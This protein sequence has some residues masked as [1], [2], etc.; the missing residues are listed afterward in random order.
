[1][2]AFAQGQGTIVI[3]VLSLWLSHRPFART[4]SLKF[5]RVNMHI[6]G[7]L[8]YSESCCNLF[9]IFHSIICLHKLSIQLMSQ[10]LEVLTTH[11]FN[12]NLDKSLSYVYQIINVLIVVI[13]CS[14]HWDRGYRLSKW[15]SIVFCHIKLRFDS[16]P[17]QLKINL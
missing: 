17:A 12:L 11:Y 13:I 15:V 14:S 5:F 9:K 10:L 4:Q 16:V 7:C 3:H 1:M 2:W 6:Y 8:T